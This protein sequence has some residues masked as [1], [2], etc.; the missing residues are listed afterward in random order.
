MCGDC[1]DCD[2][3]DAYEGK[4]FPSTQSDK[5]IDSHIDS[6]DDTSGFSSLLSSAALVAVGI[7]FG[8]MGTKY[9]PSMTN[10]QQQYR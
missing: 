8:V 3:A 4:D 9:I 7:F 5:K 1:C 6:S 2:C 10:P